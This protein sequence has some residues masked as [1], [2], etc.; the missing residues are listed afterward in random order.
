MTHGKVGHHLNV[1]ARA[2]LV[3]VAEE[4]PVRAVIERFYRPTYEILRFDVEPGAD[5]DPLQFLLR[6]AAIEAKPWSEQ[7]FRPLGRLYSVR[8]NAERAEEF[9][10]RLLELADEFA[11]A[12]EKAGPT[13][14]FAAAVYEMDVPA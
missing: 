5:A 11:A 9:A 13:F 14:G 1:L 6:Q 10:H 2:G 12:D 7:P 3:E 8:M 4:R